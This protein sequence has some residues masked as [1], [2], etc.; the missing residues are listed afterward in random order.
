MKGSGYKKH[1]TDQCVSHRKTQLGVEKQQQIRKPQQGCSPA[2]PG[3][4]DTL[5]C[6]H[7]TFTMSMG[8]GKR[9]RSVH[10]QPWA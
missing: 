9:Q 5:V 2:A 10:L 7:V 3:K 4:Q 8:P 1:N 6:S